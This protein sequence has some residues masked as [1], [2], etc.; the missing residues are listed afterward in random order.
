M[1]TNAMSGIR[2]YDPATA[3]QTTSTS[4]SATP[5]ATSQTQ[6]FLQ[7]LV[8]QI[9]NQDPTSP[10]DASTMTSQM[11]NLSM[12]QSM[13][14]MN[15]SLT[16][17]LA[18]MQASNFITQ[19]SSIGHSPLVASNQIVYNGSGSV[20][21][22]GNVANSLSDLTATITDSSGNVVNTIDLG[23]AQAGMKNFAWNGADSS[24][25]QLGAGNYYIQLN[26]TTASGATDNSTTAYVA[27]AV[28]T[29]SKSSDGKTVNLNLANGM[30]ID[31]NSVTQWD[32]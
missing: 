19:A 5:T 11:S 4:S 13:Q 21:L 29:V 7:L 6:D 30:T 18:Q 12:V 14:D 16:S 32:S 8:A 15:S 25:N 27:S 17:L 23:A 28:A 20:M 9:Q 24:G 31:A 22:G 2:V 26:G 1:T 3:N 10:M